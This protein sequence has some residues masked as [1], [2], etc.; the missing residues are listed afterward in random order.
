M[1]TVYL[2]ETRAGLDSISRNEQRLHSD[3]S[4]MYIKAII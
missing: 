1:Q 3:D 4:T 2:N